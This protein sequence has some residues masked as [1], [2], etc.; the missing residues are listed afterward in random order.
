MQRR[1]KRSGASGLNLVSL[2]DIFTILVF[3]LL[4]NSSSALQLPNSKDVELPSS[5]AQQMPKETVMLM[6]NQNQILVQGRLIATV[7]QVLKSE[8]PLIPELQTEMQLQAQNSLL[9]DEEKQEGLEITVMG[10]KKI[11]YKLLRKILATLSASNYTKISMAVM[12]RSDKQ[13]TLDTGS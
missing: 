13:D 7:E 8:K 4:V 9:S 10:D 12:K 6:V 3:F 2:M 1:H 5:T 11:P